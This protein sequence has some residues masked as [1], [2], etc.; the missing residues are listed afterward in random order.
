MFYLAIKV[1]GSH[2]LPSDALANGNRMLAAMYR[3]ACLACWTN[4]YSLDRDRSGLRRHSGNLMR[5]PD[6]HAA[7]VYTFVRSS[8]WFAV[9]LTHSA[10]RYQLDDSKLSDAR[11]HRN[12]NANGNDTS[13]DWLSRRNA[14]M[15]RTLQS[16]TQPQIPDWI[17]IRFLRRPQLIL[18]HVRSWTSILWH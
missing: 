7:T 13:E 2:P 14:K 4:A 12:D 16:A 17:A 18:M 11:S 3:Q 10:P 5:Q 9:E 15:S 8:M 6:G 1:C